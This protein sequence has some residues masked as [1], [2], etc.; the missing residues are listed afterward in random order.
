MSML[1]GDLP[2]RLILP[3]LLAAAAL[4][5]AIAADLPERTGIISLRDKP[6]TLVGPALTLGQPA[7]DAI[8]RDG[9]LTPVALSAASKGVRIV[10]TVPSLDTPVCS[11]EAAAFD[12]KI[13]ALKDVTVVLVSRD[14]P[15]SQKRACAAGHIERLVLLS[16][17]DQAALGRAWGLSIKETG[18]LA[19]AV[20]VLDAAGT[21]RWQQIVPNL[22]QEPD[23]DGALK[24]AG[25]LTGK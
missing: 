23:Y 7:P 3:T 5:G 16:D 1:A 24:A 10:L 13:A 12:Q 15:F 4:N 18:L 6:L 19:R 8:L 14:L 11:R 25:E 20:V 9:T 22:A 2:M 17:F 21:V